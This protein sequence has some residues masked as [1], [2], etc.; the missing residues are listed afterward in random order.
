MR[1]I[2]RIKEI[3]FDAKVTLQVKPVVAV[4]PISAKRITRKKSTHMP[5]L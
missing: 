1:Y 4:V 5:Y 2:E 3:L